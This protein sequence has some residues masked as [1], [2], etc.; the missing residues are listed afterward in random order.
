M[1]NMKVFDPSKTKFGIDFTG[2]SE[3]IS[4]GLRTL[5]SLMNDKRKS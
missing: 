1:Y 3:N 2:S 5:G 4:D